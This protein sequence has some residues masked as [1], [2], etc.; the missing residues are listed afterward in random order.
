LDRAASAQRVRAARLGG[1]LAREVRCAHDETA[2]AAAIRDLL[3]EGLAPILVL[4]ASAI[5]DRRDVIPAAIEQAGG[6]IV[7]LGMPVDP[8]NLLLLA[9]A[10]ETAILGV[11]GCARSLR[12]SGFDMVLERLAAGIFPSRA[13]LMT[14]GTGGLLTD[15]PAR[16]HPREGEIAPMIPEPAVAAVVLAAGRSRR[17]GPEN[18]LLVEVDGAPMIARVVDVILATRAR[19]VVIVTGHDAD[20][21]REAL[22]GRDV[23]FA[24]NPRHDEGM[25]TSLKAGIAQLGEDLDG[26]LICLGDMPRV[27]P[28]QIEALLGAFDPA[29]GRAICVPVWDRRRGNPVLFAARY[30][31]EMR[32]VEG[33][34]G[35]RSI[36]ER[37]TAEIC[38][39]PMDDRGVTLDIDTPE[40]LVALH[41]EP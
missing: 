40:A 8:G 24:H 17:M 35:A 33:D 26:A 25:S 16:M 27:R 7:H 11:P 30:F 34:V 29:D 12:R 15:I 39:V 5:V 32:L 3:A 21:V 9:R 41:K 4:G 31:P 13:D 38:Y 10:G 6:A 36:L 2:V 1:T 37:H 19:P 18:K 23:V 28:A 20:R 14:L 22:A